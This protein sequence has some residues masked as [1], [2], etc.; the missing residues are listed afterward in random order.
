VTDPLIFK[1]VDRCVIAGIT[2]D[3]AV[4]SLSSVNSAFTV[5]AFHNEDPRPAFPH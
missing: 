5:V 4:L 1:D 2:D 3:F